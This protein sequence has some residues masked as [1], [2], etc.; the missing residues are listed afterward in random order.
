ML[1]VFVAMLLVFVA[2]LLV[3]V[4]MLLV[5]VCT[6]PLARALTA[7]FT[8]FATEPACWALPFK[9]ARAPV[10]V[11][12]LFVFVAMFPVFVPMFPALAATPVALALIS[13]ASV[14]SYVP[15]AAK[16]EMLAATEASKASAIFICFSIML[17]SFYFENWSNCLA[18]SYG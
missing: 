12:M 14:L 3:F 6:A 9:V 8:V 2:M 4:A 5:F 15:S 1:F 18:A 7:V 16:V 13:A 11:W 17:I 10:F